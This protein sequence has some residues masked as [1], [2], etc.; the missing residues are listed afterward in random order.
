MTV[1]RHGI[2]PPNAG[3]MA[4]WPPSVPSD[5]PARSA[6][7][8]AGLS[9]DRLLELLESRQ[10]RTTEVRV[11]L[12]LAERGAG[13]SQLAGA[14]GVRPDEITRAGR[15]LAMRGLLR[16]QHVGERNRTR[17]AITGAGVATL[18]ALLTAVGRSDGSAA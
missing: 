11:L 14:L 8:A 6:F 9:L 10:L 7:G 13:V 17:L 12:R 1:F 3:R 16:W 5:R 4:P 2:T 18:R 15:R